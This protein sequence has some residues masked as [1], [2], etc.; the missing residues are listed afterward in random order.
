MDSQRNRL[1]P[2][3]MF[4]TTVQTPRNAQPRVTLRRRCRS[5]CLPGLI[6]QPTDPKYFNDLNDLRLK[7]NHLPSSLGNSPQHGHHHQ[8]L[9]ARNTP[10]K[11][12]PASVLRNQDIS[13]NIFSFVDIRRNSHTNGLLK[14]TTRTKE[15][16]SSSPNLTAYHLDH[17]NVAAA[18]GAAVEQPPHYYGERSLRHQ[19]MMDDMPTQ[20]KHDNRRR[21]RARSESEPHETYHH[22]SNNKHLQPDDG[23]GDRCRQD[24]N[25]SFSY[26]CFG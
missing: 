9:S 21:V 22:S 13:K 4:T 7:A 24:C 20:R 14:T 23:K 5:E 17:D 1:C 26:L 8:F 6:G 15:N 12:S 10:S 11:Y 16:I 3:P 2:Q 19:V 25:V 18:A